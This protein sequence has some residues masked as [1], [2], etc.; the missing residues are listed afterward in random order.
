MTK[1]TTVVPMMLFRSMS[2]DELVELLLMLLEMRLNWSLMMNVMSYKHI[3]ALLRIS[4]V[5]GEGS[6]VTV[7]GNAL[8]SDVATPPAADSK[9]SADDDDDDDDVD[10]FGGRD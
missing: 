4:G 10:L 3:D 9:A 8:A 2:K 7:E 1:Q 6:G 5:S